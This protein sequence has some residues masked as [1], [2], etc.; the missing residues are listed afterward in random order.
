MAFALTFPFALNFIILV[1]VMREDSRMIV[2][3]VRV[4]ILIILLA[5]MYKVGI[6]KLLLVFLRHF[7]CGVK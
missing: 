1:S 2:R 7:G 3:G 5:L 4:G 6:L